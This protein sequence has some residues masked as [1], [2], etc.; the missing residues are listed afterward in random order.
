[1]LLINNTDTSD[2]AFFKVNMPPSPQPH[3]DL[4]IRYC[5]HIEISFLTLQNRG[6]I[7]RNTSDGEKKSERRKNMT[8]RADMLRT[9]KLSMVTSFIYP[10]YLKRGLKHQGIYGLFSVSLPFTTALT[11]KPT[12]QYT[13][14]QQVKITKDTLY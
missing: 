10:L 6:V 11:C 8:R 13:D 12:V 14:V 1:M 9:D 2:G 4:P 5:K 7:D 3:K